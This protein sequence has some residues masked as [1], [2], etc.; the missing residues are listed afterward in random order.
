[1][2]MLDQAQAATPIAATVLTAGF[3]V[4]CTLRVMGML[5]TFINDD[6]KGVFTLH[7]VTLHGLEQGNPAVSMTARDL[8]IGK[9]QC[10]MIAF[11][12]SMS[13]EQTGLMPRIE[14]LAVY[15]SHYVIQGNFH[16][17]SDALVSDFIDTSR[18]QFIAATDVHIFPLF[19]AQAQVIQHAPLVY[20]HQS[21]VQ[22]HHPAGR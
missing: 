21:Q 16:M 22:L 11:Q 3:Q 7:D 20:L 15:T 9:S 14:Q 2:T 10:Q 19:V 8:F 1:M 12:D 5:Q 17:G 4:R 6:Q 18:A 13:Q